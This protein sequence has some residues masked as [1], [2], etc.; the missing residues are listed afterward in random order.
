MDRVPYLAERAKESGV[1]TAR[2]L[3]LDWIGLEVPQPVVGALR[4]AKCQHVKGAAGDDRRL[5]GAGSDE[6]HFLESCVLQDRS[7]VGQD[8]VVFADGPPVDDA[9]QLREPP[10]VRLH[11]AARQLDGRATEMQAIEVMRVDPGREQ[12]LGCVLEFEHGTDPRS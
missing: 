8:H 12:R 6:L 1:D 2:T 4:P 3:P 7:A 5:R 10:R 9:A 11:V